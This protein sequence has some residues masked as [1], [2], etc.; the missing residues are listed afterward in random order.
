MVE[1]LLKGTLESD[2][3][4]SFDWREVTYTDRNSCKLSCSHNLRAEHIFTDMNSGCFPSFYAKPY[5]GIFV[6]DPL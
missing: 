4:K 1:G 6:Q 2:W 5:V 3:F